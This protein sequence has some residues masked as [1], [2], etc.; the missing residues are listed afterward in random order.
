MTDERLR[1]GGVVVEGMDLWPSPKP[2][3]LSPLL[4][5]HGNG[6][7]NFHY[8]PNLMIAATKFDATRTN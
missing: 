2:Q 8:L 5:P 1:R 4:I 6:H 3:T 7:C